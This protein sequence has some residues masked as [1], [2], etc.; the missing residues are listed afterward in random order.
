MLK[1][2]DFFESK[3]SF[4]PLYMMLLYFSFSIFCVADLSVCFSIASWCLYGLQKIFCDVAAW[5]SPM[6]IYA[7]EK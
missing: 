3:N 6:H 7:S 1:Y 5:Y 4:L 2:S